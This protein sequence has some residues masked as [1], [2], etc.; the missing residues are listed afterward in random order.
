MLNFGYW[1]TGFGTPSQLAE[2]SVSFTRQDGEG[3]TVFFQPE[4]RVDV[5]SG[6]ADWRVG[7]QLW[8]F[9]SVG[10]YVIEAVGP[11]LDEITKVAI[12]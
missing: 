10:C 12:R 5:E 11:G 2:V 4:L 1:L 8:S 6:A 7:A 3:R 9:P